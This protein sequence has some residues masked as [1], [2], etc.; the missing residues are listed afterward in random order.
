MQ[1]IQTTEWAVPARGSVVA[2]GCFDGVHRGHRLLIET[3]RGLAAA[4]EWD[5]VVLTF[6]PHPATV[7]R[8]ETVPLLLSRAEKARAVE[9]LGADVYM[10]YPFTRDFAAWPPERFFTD[11]LA[12]L[13]CRVLV[14]GE[15]FRFGKNGAGNVAVAKELGAAH[16]ITVHVVP[17]LCENGAK[18]S[19][20]RIRRLLAEGNRTEAQALL[21][22]TPLPP[23]SPERF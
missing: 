7:L 9:A 13:C 11:V 3:A 10:E 14:V 22:F 1:I 16:N 8:N 5:F 2:A 4:E 21:S 17:P 18:I 15:D 19:S 23:G 6:E 12:R 20:T